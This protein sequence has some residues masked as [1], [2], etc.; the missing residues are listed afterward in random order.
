MHLQC[1]EKDEVLSLYNHVEQLP[2]SSYDMH[3]S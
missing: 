1:T 3:S 2:Q